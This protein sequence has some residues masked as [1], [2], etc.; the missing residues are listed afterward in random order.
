VVDGIA[1]VAQEGDHAAGEGLVV[2]NEQDAG[3]RKL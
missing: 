3:Q 2:F 1:S